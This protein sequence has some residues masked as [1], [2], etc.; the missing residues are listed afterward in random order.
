MYCC[1]IRRSPV[2]P[3]SRIDQR[4]ATEGSEFAL[5][6]LE[7]LVSESVLFSLSDQ[8]T[9]V[10]DFLDLVYLR[11]QPVDVPFFIP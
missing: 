2:G 3:R 11:L 9:L 5:R 8:V 4:K 10:P 1:L 6:E 7:K